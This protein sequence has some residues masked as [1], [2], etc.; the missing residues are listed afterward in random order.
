MFLGTGL[1]PS[2]ADATLGQDNKPFTT[3]LY[4]NGP[5]HKLAGEN[6][7]CKYTRPDLTTE[8][9]GKKSFREISRHCCI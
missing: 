7:S 9:T 2:K 4:A 3:I 1:A 6:E 5:G 8:D